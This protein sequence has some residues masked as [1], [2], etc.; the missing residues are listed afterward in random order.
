M[1]NPDKTKID[2]SIG[3]NHI[4]FKFL[5]TFIYSKVIE[6]QY[7]KYE[8]VIPIDN[9][10]KM[11]VSKDD[12]ICFNGDDFFT[13][14][15]FKSGL[16]SSNVIRKDVW[17]SIDLSKYMGLLWIHVGF[18]IEALESFPAYLVQDCLISQLKVQTK[19][20]CNGTFFNVGLNVVKMYQMMHLFKYPPKT[21]RK[22]T[23]TLKKR[24]LLDIPKAKAEGLRISKS[25]LK[26]CVSLYKMY[27]SFWL[28][29]LPLLLVPGI[30]YKPA[31]WLY[32]RGKGY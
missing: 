16:V 3:E 28:R 20:G 6:G 30:C 2:I 15:S 17:E 11:I 31:L 26:D 5:D 18:L 8:N 25:L 23:L 29:D 19:W 9:D 27:P 1:E 22:A 14:S 32:R 10:K 24:Y 12:C 13:R 7:P 4:V 21:I